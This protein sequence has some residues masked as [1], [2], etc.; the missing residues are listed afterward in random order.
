[1]RGS[2]NVF[3]RRFQ[4]PGGEFPTVFPTVWFG[5]WCMGDGTLS[6]FYWRLREGAV[7]VGESTRR[8][9]M[10]HACRDHLAVLASWRLC[11]NGRETNRLRA[12][13]QVGATF[14]RNAVRPRCDERGGGWQSPS[15]RAWFPC[16]GAARSPACLGRACVGRPNPPPPNPADTVLH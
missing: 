3:R 7:F 16:A 11:V 8:A 15:P 13:M 9:R 1:M 14:D 6:E 12:V 10:G 4:A 5:R 2:G